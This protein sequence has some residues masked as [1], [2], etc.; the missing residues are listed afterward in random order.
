MKAAETRLPPSHEGNVRL[1]D[2]MRKAIVTGGLVA[3]GGTAISALPLLL[4]SGW[5]P[6][7]WVAYVVIGPYWLFHI[8]GIII[9]QNIH[10]G[11][12]AYQGC[13]DIH[14]AWAFWWSLGINS[15]I[16]GVIGMMTSWIR[17]KRGSRTR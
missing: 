3:A 9:A 16:G 17:N 15:I 6:P 4:P 13:R 11:Q 10:N 8:L 12:C 1:E 14:I 5:H 7:D 2:E